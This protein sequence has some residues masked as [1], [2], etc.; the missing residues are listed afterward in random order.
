MNLPNKLTVSR[1]FLTF[2]FML[3]LFSDGIAA[4]IGALAVFFIASLT[5]FLDG[6]L[7]RR[8]DMITDFGKLM[9]PIADKVLVLSAFLAFIELRLVPAWMVVLIISREFIVTGVRVLA[10][11]KKVVLPAREGGKHKTVSQMSAIFVI[12]IFLVFREI[13]LKYPSL[14]SPGIEGCFKNIILALMW[15]TTP[16][17]LVS[18]G[19]FLYKNRAVFMHDGQGGHG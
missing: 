4:R 5:D 9:D 15:W 6:Y 12:L 8:Y 14:W 2:V 10:L 18:G 19:A 16:L 3:L 7:A 17:T 11:S 1:I 13:G